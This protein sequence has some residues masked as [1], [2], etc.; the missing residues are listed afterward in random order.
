MIDTSDG[1][2][3]VKLISEE[4]DD[5]NFAYLQPVL[6]TPADA[7]VTAPPSSR[8]HIK[9]RRLTGDRSRQPVH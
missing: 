5:C 2:E 7:A 9:L 4:D 6:G 8:K 1:V 3:F